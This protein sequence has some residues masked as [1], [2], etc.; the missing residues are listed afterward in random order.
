MM[1]FSEYDNRNEYRR[2]IAGRMAN[3]RVAYKET[4]LFICADSVMER[5]ALDAVMALRH[6]LDAYIARHP[7]FA[8]SLAPLD[9]LPDAPTAAADM[10]RAAKAADVGPMAAVAGAFAAHVGRGMLEYSR[11]VIVEN[12]GDIFMKADA[13][14]TV[15]IYAGN[16]QLSMKLGLEVAPGPVSICTS[17]GTIGPSLSFG[18]ADAA[19]VVSEDACLADAC[20]TRLGNEL[21]S[22][23]DIS[24]ALE[25]IIGIPGVIGAVAI[26]GDK[27]GA[28]GDIQLKAL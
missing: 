10:C 11:E 5:I 3:W 22:A 17:S 2:M 18:N 23:D 12:G 8:T 4:E 15:A 7:E 26:V 16:S 1:Q 13:V 20:A 14:R 27:C 6:E 28:V 9:P 19:V 24:R 21:K 25:L